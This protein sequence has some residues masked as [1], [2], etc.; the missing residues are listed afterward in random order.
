[1]TG[2]MKLIWRRKLPCYAKALS[3]SYWGAQLLLFVALSQGLI[4]KN[5]M[6]EDYELRYPLIGMLR[7]RGRQSHLPIPL[8]MNALSVISGIIFQCYFVHFYILSKVY[9]TTV[10]SRLKTF[11]PN[12]KSWGPYVRSIWWL[13]SWDFTVNPIINIFSIPGINVPNLGSD[14]LEMTR[15]DVIEVRF[16]VSPIMLAKP[17]TITL[18]MAIESSPPVKVL[19]WV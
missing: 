1:M 3:I 8:V 12:V 10:Y 19:Y 17:D 6:L 18:I 14:S 16:S 7:L 5:A 2:F 15:L 13:K 11:R 4:D 9:Y